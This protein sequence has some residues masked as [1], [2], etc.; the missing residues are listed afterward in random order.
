[1]KPHIPLI[2]GAL[3]LAATVS[4]DA[5]AAEATGAGSTFVYPILS[6]WAG[7][8]SAKTGDTIKYQSIGSGGGIAQIKAAAVDFGASDM[9]LP[10]EDL[11]KLGLVQF[12]LVIGGVVPVVNIDGVRPGQIRFTGTVLADIYLGKLRKWN[13]PAIQAI[14]PDL[15]LPDAQ[16]TVVHRT[17]GSGTTFNWVNYL[18]KVSP[19]WKNA[20]VEGVSIEWPVGV[21]GKGNEGVAVYVNQI[22]NSI[23]YVEYA[24]ALH[25]KMTFGLVQNKL[26]HYVRP[27]ADTFR[28]AA[29]GA[30][31][32]GTKDFFLVMT[33]APGENAY[34]I[35]AT[36]FILMYKAPKNPVRSKTALNFFRWSLEDGQKA[37]D[38]LDYVPLPASLVR[39][40]EAY[41][42]NAGLG[43]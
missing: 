31:W 6:K 12:P 43:M 15:K 8:Y 20:V 33:D 2:C 36:S 39:Q 30:E 1:M 14:N 26:G 18:A 5:H 10:S 28:A 25:Y 27:D 37:A 32:G 21:G 23:G 40:I 13:D 22:K 35:T 19:A 24:Y 38:E 3:L 4:G 17:D 11:A 7:A 42:G 29:E 9:P 41:W 34:P 16:I